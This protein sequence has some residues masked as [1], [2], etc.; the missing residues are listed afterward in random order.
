MAVPEKLMRLRSLFALVL[1]TALFTSGLTLA[2]PSPHS[3]ASSLGGISWQLVKFQG[4]DDKLLQPGAQAKYTINFDANGGMSVQI[5]CNRGHGTWKSP[6][7]NQ[8][9][10]GP[11]ALTLAM[12][13]RARLTDRLPKDW[14]N[15]RSYIIKDGHLF[16]SLVADGGIY[17]FEPINLKASASLENTHWQL[18]RLGNTPVMT[19][20]Q[21]QQPYLTFDSK[22][23][24]VAGSG[25][26]NRL[27]G[28]YKRSGD[29]LTF[30][31][32]ASTRMAC[33]QGMETENA[34]LQALQHVSTWKIA[35]NQLEL[36]D[37]DGNLVARFEAHPTN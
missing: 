15:V 8:L 33:V 26:C 16:L 18:V 7:P 21:R 3:A 14:L 10:F 17:E 11:L 28:S 37:T 24:R 5:D 34:F 20:S 35:G 30:G 31:Q 23:L 6:G 12:C 36:S 4:G 25:G 19:D 2:K 22:S 29:Q 1:F 32:I 13:P 27:T 9:N